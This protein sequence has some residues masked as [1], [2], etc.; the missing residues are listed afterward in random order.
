[1]AGARFIL[2]PGMGA[3]ERL[4]GPQRA[5]GFDFEVPT[6][7]I[8]HP[9]DDMPAY[10]ARLR[11]IL[12]LTGPC[13][14]GGVS[15]GGMVACELAAI[16]QARCVILIATCRD[17][18]AIPGY[19]WWVDKVARFLPDAVIRHRC[20]ASSRIMS[21]LESLNDQQR[22]LI[23]DMASNIPVP[24]LRGAGRMILNW[25]GRRQLPCPAYQIH[26]ATDRIIPLRG[27]QPDEVV[28]RGGHLINLTH[29]DQVNRFI[30]RCL[31]V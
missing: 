28:P 1:M 12:G 26:G 19:Y 13:V 2:L 24:L 10:A 22:E 18:S 9:H 15:F 14:V 23:R 5:C 17:I 29:A 4:F 21:K 6:M 20:G 27:V 11:E 31:A 16:C 8:P 30:A 7:P 3:D 25:A